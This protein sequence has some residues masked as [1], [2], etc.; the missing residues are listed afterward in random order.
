MMSQRNYAARTTVG[1]GRTKDEIEQE[2]RRLGATRGA[3]F[4][5]DEHA[6]AVIMFEREQTR[7]R[8]VLPLPD[9]QADQFQWSPA[10]QVRYTEARQQQEWR[11]ACNERWRALGAYVKALRVGVEAGILHIEEALLPYVVLPSGQTVAEYTLPQL[12]DAA[13]VGRM[14]P[15]LPG[16]GETTNG[17]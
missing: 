4:D 15:L 7:Y 11:Q 5:D 3:F 16:M 8:L 6:Q 14:P 12:A 9:P 1:I 17:R 2:L 10:R 13:N